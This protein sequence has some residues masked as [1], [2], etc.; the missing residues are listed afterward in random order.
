MES[1]L[2]LA[3]HTDDMEFG[4]GGT[5]SKLL[6]SGSK[7]SLLVFSTCKESLPEEFTVKDIKLEQ[8][9]SAKVL[10]LDEKDII[11]F[12]FPVRRF[13]EYR[14]EILEIMIEYRENNEFTKVF[15]PSRN[16]IHQDHEVIC[17]ES[18]RAFKDKQ[19]LGYEL[20][21]NNIESN[22]NFFYDLD[23]SNVDL[24]IEAINCFKSQKH[25]A[26]NS[27][28]ILSLAKIRG[29]QVKSGFAEAFELIRWLE[30]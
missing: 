9:A 12:D 22:N 4:C 24:K 29:M 16:D 20:P 21:W 11:F 8:I 3:P 25:R 5:I 10:G 18:I 13:D 1:I 19:L 23:K 26:Y 6:Q 28:H 15:T 17:V 2:V 7:V 30:K 27:K 14:Q